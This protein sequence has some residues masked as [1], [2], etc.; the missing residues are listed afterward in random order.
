MCPESPQKDVW[1]SFNITYE[2]DMKMFMK[3]TGKWIQKMEMRI[4][5]NSEKI[6]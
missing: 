6:K 5:N 3:E 2:L 1:K 4:Q